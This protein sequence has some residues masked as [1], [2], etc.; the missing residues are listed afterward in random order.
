MSKNDGRRSFIKK[1]GIGGVGAAILPGTHLTALEESGLPGV[2]DE[3]KSTRKY[4]GSV[5]MK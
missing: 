3:K 5:R 4:N 1:I 2:P